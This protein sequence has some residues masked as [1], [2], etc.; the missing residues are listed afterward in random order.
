MRRTAENKMEERRL[1][2]FEE[3]KG[4][5]LGGHAIHGLLTTLLDI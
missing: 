4:A 1:L 2:I 5:E 3:G